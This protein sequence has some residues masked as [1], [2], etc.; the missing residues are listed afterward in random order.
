[1]SELDGRLGEVVADLLG[2]R[3]A[4]ARPVVG[5]FTPAERF[6]VTL[7]DGRSA[8]V[9]TG[10]DGDAS[11]V[12]TWLRQEHAVYSELE[13]PFLPELLG[14]HEDPIAPVLVL[15]DLSHGVWP[16]PWDDERIARTLAVT[17][18][19]HAT[20]A[21][22]GLPAARRLDAWV[23]VAD[24]AEPLLALGVC[25]R[26]WLERHLDTL[27]AATRTVEFEGDELCHYD[28]RSDNLCFDGERTLLVDWNLARV[29]NGA[30]DVAFWLPSLHLE[31]GPLPDA[32]LP[33]AASLAA[34][35]AGFFADRAGLP[36]WPRAPR[37]RPFQEA[38]L[39]VALP[40]AARALEL[41][42][43]N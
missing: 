28:L 23:A 2:E 34:V 8:F 26:E 12:A 20:T 9:K 37:V 6:V 43:P 18:S 27:V 25:T 33:D 42:P 17:E 4:A 13:A 29:G 14:W 5:G 22:P 3:V 31:G 39:R 1:M 24:D 30:I 11:E 35:V 7:A 32:V 40:W 15:E 21:P 38:Q 10:V 16:P 36:P 41:P 19:V